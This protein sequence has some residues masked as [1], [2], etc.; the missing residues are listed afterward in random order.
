MVERQTEN[1]KVES[2]ILFVDT[3]P[4]NYYLLLYLIN[5][6]FLNKSNILVNNLQKKKKIN[7][8]QNIYLIRLGNIHTYQEFLNYQ[9]YN[10]HYLQN[11][12]K[13]KLK[14]KNINSLYSLPK[15][16]IKYILF[17]TEYKNFKQFGIKYF[18]EIVYMFL[19]NIWLKN[20]K[21]ICLYIKRKL[22]SVH[23]KKH[24]VYFLFFCKIL[25]NYVLPNFQI[26]QIKGITLKFKGKLG[27]GGTA[28][29]KTIFY[30]KGQYSLS[31][32]FLSL[33]RNKWDVWTKTGTVGCTFQIFY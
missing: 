14:E 11:I 4:I 28:R 18:N 22:D 21:N 6:D 30:H 5:K 27:R 3:I 31:N 12:Y 29:K 20:S 2:S 10:L 23:F 7:Y 13:I 26:L 32:K 1:L 17:K 19:V 8:L 25:S 33:N 24:R 9:Y 15:K 16:L